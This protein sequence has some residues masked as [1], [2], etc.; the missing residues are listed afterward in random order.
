M[1]LT[2]QLEHMINEAG[3]VTLPTQ[4]PTASQSLHNPKKRPYDGDLLPPSPEKKTKRHDV[5]FVRGWLKLKAEESDVRHSAVSF[6]GP[7]DSVEPKPSLG[8][9]IL[10]MSLESPA[11]LALKSP[12]S[13]GNPARKHLSEKHLGM[14]CCPP[15]D[16]VSLFNVPGAP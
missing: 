14:S 7:D 4:Q 1:T 6:D 2:N 8:G 9:L 11:A 12:H 15:F 13:S 10:R 16:S 5:F 3:S